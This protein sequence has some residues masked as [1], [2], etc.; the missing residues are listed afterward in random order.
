MTTSATTR[1][2]QNP[3]REGFCTRPVQ[4][5]SEPSQVRETAAVYRLSRARVSSLTATSRHA[6]AFRWLDA[7]ARAEPEIRRPRP[8][9]SVARVH[10]LTA[11]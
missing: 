11:G 6:L 9:P 4:R 1:H 5:G 8:R 10:A 7:R 2:G 3:S